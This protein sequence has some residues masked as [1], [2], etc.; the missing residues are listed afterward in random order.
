MNNVK[1]IYD[2]TTMGYSDEIFLERDISTIEF[3]HRVLL[4]SKRKD[5]PLME[6]LK[7]IGIT[8]SNMDEFVM[9]RYG[10]AINKFNIDNEAVTSTGMRYKD[11]LDILRIKI[12]E[13]YNNISSANNMILD[14]L[15]EED[16]NILKYKDLDIKDRAKANK[17]FNEEIYP[18]IT[19]L[20][21]DSTNDL[22][23]INNSELYMVC[24]VEDDSVEEVD[25]MS[26]IIISLDKLD[27][28]FHISD[29]TTNKFIMIED[30]I[31]HN[32]KKIFVNKKVAQYTLFRAIRNMDTEVD[33]NTNVP[34]INRMGEVLYRR[35]LGDVLRVEILKGLDKNM[36]KLLANILG[37]DRNMFTRVSSYIDLKFLMSLPKLKNK[38]ELY[39]TEYKPIT[40]T[41]FTGEYD[42][43]K[44]I[45]KGD[46]MLNHPYES[47]DPVLNF[48]DKAANDDNV[49]SIRQTL[50]RVS[51]INSPIVKSLCEAAEKG[52]DVMILLEVKARF[53]ESQNMKMINKL[54]QSG[55]KIVYGL[56]HLK[57]HCKF[58][59]VTKK[60]K[61]GVKQYAH[62]STG[63][64]ND[65][66]A[67]LYTD[68]SYFTS[69]KVVTKDLVTVFNLLSGYSYP[70]DSISK[71]SVSPFNI[72]DTIINMIE[73]EG[74]KGKEGNICLKLNSLS[75]V[76]IIDAIYRA[77][78]K[79]ARV[80]IICRGAC[81]ATVYRSNG[82]R[83]KRFKIRS[84]VGRYL[85]HS[86]IYMFG[87]GNSIKA[88]ISSADLLTRN[89][90]R[91][92]EIL[93]PIT[94]KECINQLKEYFTILWSDRMNSFKLKGLS[95]EERDKKKNSKKNIDS[96]NEMMRITNSSYKL[97]NV[98]IVVK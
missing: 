24:V 19:P 56:E 59:L 73:R 64:Y 58:I 86:R 91:R 33:S 10:E 67:K 27:R 28:V 82:D 25:N 14:E 38:P 62:I 17:Y 61:K 45:D 93:L 20:A 66:T 79:G 51:S 83:R 37:V 68:I 12:D 4:Q 3:N 41:I 50:Y 71:L 2:K 63:N 57:T 29:K 95:Y 43:F 32:L 77:N 69:D 18:L 52:K 34:L 85:E 84:I 8:S 98:P 30:I 76:E 42:M 87:K 53:D 5:F 44:L 92:V 81:S 80:N 16:I 97:K 36:E 54:R 72:R 39:F 94:N 9:V 46:I 49:I 47:Y 1:K 88:F 65:K 11:L 48:L 26:F 74:K 55:C 96:Q 40:P 35:S 60:G 7:F 78:D 6:R 22:I 15:K 75:D 89:L 21:Y 70:K 23:K 13:I 90:D 31:K